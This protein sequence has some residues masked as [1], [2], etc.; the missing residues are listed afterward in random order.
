M[1]PLILF[2]RLLAPLPLKVVR[3]LGWLLGQLLYGLAAERRHVV[4]VN[5]ALC[6]PHWTAAERRAVARAHVVMV[7]QSLLAEPGCGMGP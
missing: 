1:H 5:L 7:M 3:A 6:F 2:M 4:D